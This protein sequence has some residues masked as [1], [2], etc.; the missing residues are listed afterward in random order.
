[1]KPRQL[2]QLPLQSSQSG[3]TIIESLVALIVAGILLAAIAP[4]LVLSTATRVQARRVEQAT[5]AAKA[6]IDGVGAK[7]ISDVD[8]KIAVTTLTAA[9][10]ANLRTVSSSSSDYLLSTVLVPSTDKKGL[11]CFNKDATIIAPSNPTTAPTCTAS[12]V[13]F[14][15]QPF[16]LAVSGS[17]ADKGQGYRLAV[18]VYR[19][20]AFSG[21]DALKK[22]S[23]DDG[24]QKTQATFTGGLGNRKVPLVEMTT[25][26]VRG[27]PSYSALC[28]RLGGC[29]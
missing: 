27:Q 13:Q 14:Y 5:Q 20:D 19:G 24:K 28:D 17:D 10:A 25:E 26:I 21:T 1:M 16:R 18:R 11:F 4:V 2:Q 3:F 15:I 9:T 7:T 22:T 8:N 23:D 12:Q 29:Q 6:F